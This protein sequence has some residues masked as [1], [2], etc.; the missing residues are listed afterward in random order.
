MA[1]KDYGIKV[2]QIGKSGKFVAKNKQGQ[3]IAKE[4]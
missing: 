4:E 3:E 1:L 2:S